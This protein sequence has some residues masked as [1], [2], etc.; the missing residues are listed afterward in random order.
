MKDKDKTKYNSHF[1]LVPSSK[2]LK[3]QTVKNKR[4]NS[5]PEKNNINK[6]NSVSNMITQ[7]QQTK[8]C[9]PHL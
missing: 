3:D 9:Q 8:Q 4:G 5:V 6:S 7:E 1:E 2:E